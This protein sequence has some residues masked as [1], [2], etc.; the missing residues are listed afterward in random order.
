MNV[1]LG[2]NRIVLALLALIVLLGANAFGQAISGDVT[3]VVADA[4]GAVIVNA[5]V[6][7]RNEETGVTTTASTNAT[8]VYRLSNL[9]VGNYT[10]TAAAKGFTTASVKGLRVVLNNV[11]TSNFK[12]EVGGTSTSVE[13]SAAGATID[14]TTA[15]LQSTFEARQTAEL[16]MAAKGQGSGIWNLSLL[17]A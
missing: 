5:S 10:V 17:G 16:P 14:T 3:G 2:R 1:V 13:V 9:S 4:S 11:Q 6:V 7:A 8:G 15:Q 12:L